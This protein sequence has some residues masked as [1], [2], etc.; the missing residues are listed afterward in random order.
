MK[1]F[2]LAVLLVSSSLSSC[3]QAQPDTWTVVVAS[4][5]AKKLR[6]LMIEVAKTMGLQIRLSQPYGQKENP[7]RD[8]ILSI[9]GLVA[10]LEIHPSLNEVTLFSN[11]AETTEKNR[12]LLLSLY[13][14]FCTESNKLSGVHE[15]KQIGSVALP[16][17]IGCP[18]LDSLNDKRL[19]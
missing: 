8:F 18:P 15:T 5:D 3:M 4:K 14:R 10:S 7:T 2:I 11:L 12:P 19:R 17:N 6:N 13:N 16:T 9:D 1:F